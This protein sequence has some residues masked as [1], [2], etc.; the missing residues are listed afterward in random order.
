MKYKIDIPAIKLRGKFI[1][2]NSFATLSSLDFSMW[3]FSL[4]NYV[5]LFPFF[6][7]WYY[8]PTFKGNYQRNHFY[9]QESYPLKCYPFRV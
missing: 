8:P 5:Y 4:Y 1:Q 3:E 9:L 7:G 2:N 6:C